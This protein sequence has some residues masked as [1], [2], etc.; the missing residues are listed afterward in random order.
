MKC[1]NRPDEGRNGTGWEGE[2]TVMGE[3][4]KG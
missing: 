3:L 1:R 4:E 2:G